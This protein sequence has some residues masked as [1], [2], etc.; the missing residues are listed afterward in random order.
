MPGD[1]ES[2]ATGPTP[3]T[4]PGRR[5]HG[6]RL[7]YDLGSS[8]GEKALKH[9]IL[10]L[11]AVFALGVLVFFTARPTY[12][13]F[14]DYRARS[15][16]R[17]AR[18]SF[19]RNQTLEGF[20]LLG[21][22]LAL[23]PTNT[24][25]I[26]ELAVRL[27][28]LGLPEA[29]TYWQQLVA[30]GA[31]TREDRLRYFSLCLV[32]L[33]YDLLTEEFRTLVR[34]AD[35]DPAVLQL[36]AHAAL[37]AGNI[38]EAERRG[39]EALAAG[40]A[41]PV[42]SAILGEALL[43]SG[44]PEVLEEGRRRLWGVATNQ[45]PHQGVALSSLEVF[46]RLDGE[47]LRRLRSILEARAKPGMSELLTLTRVRLRLDTNDAPAALGDLARRMAAA[48]LDERLAVSRFLVQAGAFEPAAQLIPEPEYRTNLAVFAW[49]VELDAWRGRW[50]EVLAALD[51]TNRALPPVVRGGLRGWML[52]ATE[53]PEAAARQFQST[54]ER[55]AHVPRAV[56]ELQFL[57]QCAE[58]AGLPAVA[59]NA[60][61][62]RLLWDFAVVESARDIL[63]LLEPNRELR[64]RLPALRQLHRYMPGDPPVS[65]EYGY[66]ASLCG[67]DLDE[68]RSV[69]DSFRRQ[70]PDSPEFTVGLAFARARQ[71]KVAEAA[72][73]IEERAIT[74]D[75][76]STRW[77]VAYLHILAAAGQREVVRTLARRLN[78]ADLFKEELELL[79]PFLGK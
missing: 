5:S 24:E 8:T 3:S 30:R 44:R 32:F 28:D 74:L 49:K 79:A 36:A 25:I 65:A 29:L 68:A 19:D 2:P 20:R 53:G 64:L 54:L 21:T 61:E 73:L 11:A 13:L 42:C 10:P 38:P 27:S 18:R 52:A 58:R 56:D 72:S 47:D 40:N 50:P 57:A 1:P 6:R 51:N 43:R 23:S 62:R 12:R 59:V 69:F 31:A 22:A 15:L 26:R 71:E 17:D 9:I 4:G 63:R 16:A 7:R 60:L 34:Q 78:R 48:P 66:I 46:G 35:G 77:Q 55:V 76:L 41:N 45:G 39:R 75:G 70:F 37:V 14:K 33:R 67:E